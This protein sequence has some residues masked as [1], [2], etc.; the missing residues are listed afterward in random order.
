MIPVCLS[1]SLMLLT[2]MISI[3]SLTSLDTSLRSIRFS[4]GMKA[5]VTPAL[6]AA[7]SFSL[8][9]PIGVTEP[10][11]ATSPV[12]AMCGSTLLPESREAKAVVS[13][14]PADGPSFGTAPSGI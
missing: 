14:T 6:W 4:S 1:M 7:M 12:M 13:V 9:P 3:C 5:L 2:G 8:S 10:L 11:K